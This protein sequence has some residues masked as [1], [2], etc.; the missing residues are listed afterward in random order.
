MATA[1]EFSGWL[2]FDSLDHGS[3]VD[4]T[5]AIGY[6]FIRDYNERWS[7][8][9]SRFKGGQANARNAALAVMA[10]ATPQLIRKLDMDG[11]SVTFIPALASK[12]RVAT[13]NGALSVLA[14]GC[15]SQCGSAFMLES[16]TK[17]PHATLHAPGTTVEKR[18]DILSSANYKATIF[19]TPNVFV[20]DDFITTGLTLAE[21]ATAIKSANPDVKVYGIVL[22]KNEYSDRPVTND[23]ISSAWEEAWR[24]YDAQ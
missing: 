1:Y 5:F 2:A 18:T 14:K 11:K 4:Q 7:A 22:G 3:G 23:H 21:I 6:K 10:I 17:N 20:V 9:F 13:A 16:L 8:R 15:S 12:E 19:T 24:R